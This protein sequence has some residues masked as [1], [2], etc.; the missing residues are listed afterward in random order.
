MA[1]RDADA[2]REEREPIKIERD[3]KSHLPLRTGNTLTDDHPPYGVPKDAKTGEPLPVEEIDEEEVV[4]EPVS[5]EKPDP[6]TLTAQEQNHW[7][8]LTG[9]RIQKE[10]PD[11]VP[12]EGEE[13]TPKRATKPGSNPGRPSQGLPG[14][15]PARPD[16]GLP[17]SGPEPTPHR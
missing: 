10:D 16:Q 17:G 5:P 8:V 9:E 3:P 14:G 12:P 13:G 15:R 4:E 1:K 11:A 7:E 2:E 6:V